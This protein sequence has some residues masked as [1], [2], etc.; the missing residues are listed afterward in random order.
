LIDRWGNPNDWGSSATHLY[1]DITGSF[2]GFF[3]ISDG[4]DFL[5]R[6]N[7]VTETDWAAHY[8]DEGYDEGEVDSYATSLAASAAVPEPTSVCLG[9]LG[10]TL[11]L[12][13]K[14]RQRLRL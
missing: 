2:V 14:L 11:F 3:G 4:A 10:L 8:Y 7:G 5:I 6:N 9:F 12:G 1:S 13:R